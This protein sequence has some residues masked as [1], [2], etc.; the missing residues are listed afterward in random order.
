MSIPTFWG[1]SEIGVGIASNEDF[2]AVHIV[3]LSLHANTVEEKLWE[4]AN[5]LG[6]FTVI[7]HGTPQDL[8]NEMFEKSKQF[9]DQSYSAKKE[10]L[11]FNR[12]MNCGYEFKE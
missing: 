9:F 5:N 2:A 3:D 4:A 12:S 8:I 10:Q 1:S 7:N 11:P 6:F